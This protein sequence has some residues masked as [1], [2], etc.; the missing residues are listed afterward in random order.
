MRRAL[1]Y[2]FSALLMMLAACAVPVETPENASSAAVE[3]ETSKLTPIEDDGV[4]LSPTSNDRQF[5]ADLLYEALQ[6]LDN[7]RLLT[8]VDDNAHGRFK[9]VLAY[10]PGNEIA[11]QGLKDIVRRYLQLAEQS[12]RRG[13]F[14]EAKLFI[15][16]AKFVDENDDRIASV[17]LAL[18]AEMNSDDLFFSLNAGDFAARS[19]AAKAQ[20]EEIARETQRTNAFF[21]IT[22]P[23]DDLGRWM[24]GVMRDAV[25][26]F[27]LRGNIE[28]SSQT[29]IRLRLPKDSE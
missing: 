13:L 26:G 10:E 2:L 23:N 9:R 8:P 21:L 12:M 7:D 25:P 16:N 22:A 17:W 24:F 3:G 28:L 19:D 14:E 18:Q 4:R 29:S 27:R 20:L 1:K 11:L 6:A 5:I 15:D